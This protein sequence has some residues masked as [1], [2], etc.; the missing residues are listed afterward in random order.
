MVPRPQSLNPDSI[1]DPSILQITAY[2]NITTIKKRIKS[3]EKTQIIQNFQK[4]KCEYKPSDLKANATGGSGDD[5]VNIVTGWV[6][7]LS[8]VTR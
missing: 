2:L 8:L 4:N 7:I 5:A 1:L 3:K 6:I